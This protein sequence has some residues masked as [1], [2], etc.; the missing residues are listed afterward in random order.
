MLTNDE[1][2]K[3]TRLALIHIPIRMFP[4]L[5]Q[6]ILR[7][8]FGTDESLAFDSLQASSTPEE[9]KT[10]MNR[11]TFL[12]VSFTPV[13]CSIV[14]SRKLA[15]DVFKT[16]AEDFNVIVNGWEQRIV[17]NATS[18]VHRAS[19]SNREHEGIVIYPDDYIA[20]EVNGQG[21][22]G[23]RVLELTGPLAMAGM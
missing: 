7:I 14:C 1:N 19:S 8:L 9:K 10:W 2:F 6:P 21:D 17:G 12:N 23:Q 20:V 15:N 16:L 13:E 4:Y 5:I 22:A 3:D 18:K 11:H